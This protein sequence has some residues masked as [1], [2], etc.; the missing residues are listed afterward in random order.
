MQLQFVNREPELRELEAAARKGGLL[1]VYGRRRIGK[2]RLLRH[3]LET[4][5]GLYSQ[6]IE[7]QRDLQIQQVF[8]DLRTRLETQIVPKTWQEFLEILTLQEKRW[9]LCLDEFPY[10]TTVDAS[11]PSQLQKWVDHS[12]PGGCL[13]ILA[14]SS[15]RMMHDLFLHRAAPLYGRATKLLQVQP[16]GLCSLL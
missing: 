15:T 9:T 4:R 3:W 10:L 16:D 12:L 7:A 13:L 8:Q 6:A 14:G 5:G 11:L 2:T 1:V